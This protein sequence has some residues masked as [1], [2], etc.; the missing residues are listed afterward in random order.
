MTGN[1]PNKV[2]PIN[3][4]AHVPSVKQSISV[5]I[6][7]V[8][9]LQASIVVPVEVVERH[10]VTTSICDVDIN[11]EHRPRQPCRRHSIRRG[12]FLQRSR[13]CGRIGPDVGGLTRCLHLCVGRI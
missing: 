4:R 11:R 12:N 1:V 3:K 9:E 13:I 5:C 6:D 8:D 2:L 7:D 10:P